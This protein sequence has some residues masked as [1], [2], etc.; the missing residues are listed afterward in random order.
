MN[1]TRWLCDGCASTIEIAHTD[2]FTTLEPRFCPL[3]GHDGLRKVKPFTG[4]V[5]A[6]CIVELNVN[7][8]LAQL[9]FTEWRG[10]NNGYSRFI[11]YLR[12]MLNGE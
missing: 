6:Q 1:I 8:E 12:N 4:W 11:D 5:T 3:C 7:P 10:N 2:T 9:L